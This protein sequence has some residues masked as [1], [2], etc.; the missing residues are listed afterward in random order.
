MKRSALAIGLAVLLAGIG[1]LAVLYYVRQAD[2]RALAGKD[3]VTVLVATR[4]V[5]AGTTAGDARDT[6]L[7]RA[8]PM[9]ADSVPADALGT[10]GPD[11]AALVAGADIQPGQLVLR[12]LFVAD[13]PATAGLPIPKGKVALTLALGVTQQVAGYVRVGSTV[14]VF[15]THTDSGT[16]PAGAAAPAGKAMTTRVLLPKVEVLAVGPAAAGAQ[17]A[18]PAAGSTPDGAAP[19]TGQVMLTF[20]VDTGQA[21]RLI[22]ASQ[23]GSLHLALLTEDST[24]TPGAGVTTDS[25]FSSSREGD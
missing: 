14:A 9:P 24:V 19:A 12:S 13:R 15:E 22:L 7:V 3:A 2:A 16:A 10:I 17:P 20:A 18:A 23:T 1:T 25:L 8:E 11:I 4:R 21:E 5:P 6:G